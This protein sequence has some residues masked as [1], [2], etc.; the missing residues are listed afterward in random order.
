MYKHY[1]LGLVVLALISPLGL[2]ADGTAWGEW[3][4]DK[5][6]ETLGFVPQGME[7]MGD[8]WQALFPDYSMKFL[9]DSTFSQYVGYIF[10]A[11]IG[12]VIIY[13]VI[14]LIGKLLLQQKHNS[15][16]QNKQS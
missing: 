5:L 3:D 6:K 2:L 4:G 9:G 1:W 16:C 15:I 12:A 14:L 13:A 8:L 11:I 7:Q 10:S